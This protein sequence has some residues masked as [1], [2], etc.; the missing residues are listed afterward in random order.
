MITDKVVFNI[1]R[2]NPDNDKKPYFQEF[3]IPF[4]RKDLTVLRDSTIFRIG[5]ITP[6]PFVHPA[7]RRFAVLMPCISMG[8]IAWPVTP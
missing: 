5:W 3:E 8:N 6:W 7:G 1:F 4:V 2:F